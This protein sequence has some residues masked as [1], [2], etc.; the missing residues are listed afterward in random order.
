MTIQGVSVRAT[1]NPRLKFRSAVEFPTRSAER[2]RLGTLNQEPPRNTR[3]EQS[4]PCVH[5]LPSDD[6]PS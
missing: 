2:R 3:F 4:P 5:G 6:A 1:R